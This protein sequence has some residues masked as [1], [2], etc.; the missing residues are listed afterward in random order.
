MVGL[1]GMAGSMLR[2]L[3]ALVIK[4]PS[5]P[6]STLVV[7]IAG[8]FIIAAVLGVAFKNQVFDQHW[9]LFL[10]TG[11]C[12]GFTTF[13]TFS[14]ESVQML[15]QQRYA[16]FALYI[17]VSLIAGIAAVFGGFWLTTHLK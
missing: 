3:V 16:A 2:Y 15:Q 8:S 14:V 4:N 17:S 12:G 9:R 10:T 11:V 13:S 1:G 7:N 5:F 6:F